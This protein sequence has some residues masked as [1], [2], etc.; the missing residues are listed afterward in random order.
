MSTY[1]H[2]LDLASERFE[3]AKI[4]FEEEKFHTASHLYINA[5]INYHNALCQKFLHKI[6]SH[7]AHSDTTYFSE[8]R[9]AIGPNFQK[10]KDAYDFLIGYKNQSD[11]GT[12]MSENIAKQIRRKADTIKEIAE[13]LL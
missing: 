7:K 9:K 11:Y 2:H 12:E 13:I 6:P 3:L 10:Y 4:Q 8:L 1:R 5:V